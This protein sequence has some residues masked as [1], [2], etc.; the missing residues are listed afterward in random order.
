MGSE[1]NGM[2][3]A[4]GG[5]HLLLRRHLGMRLH[6][7]DHHDQQ[8]RPQ[9]H[10][11][12]LGQGLLADVTCAGRQ[13]LGKQ[14]TQV[15]TRSPLDRK[16]TPR[17]QLPVIRCTQ[18]RAKQQFALSLVRCRLAQARHGNTIEQSIESIHRLPLEQN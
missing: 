3:G 11:P 5:D 15:L 16:K 10:G 9:R 6:V 2:G 1:Q 13:D 14:L 8:R 12:R 7:R 18:C 17:P 4:T